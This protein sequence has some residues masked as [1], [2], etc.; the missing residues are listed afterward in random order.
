[1]LIAA[2]H[3]KKNHPEIAVLYSGEVADELLRGYL[4]NRVKAT[5]AEICADMKKRLFDISMFDGLRA[6]RTVA[7]VGME[8]RLPFFSKALLNFALTAPWQYLDPNENGGI[9]KALLRAAFRGKGIIPDTIINRT[10]NAFSDATSNLISSGSEWKE[11]LKQEAQNMV[12]LDRYT[13][14]AEIY[15]DNTPDTIEDMWYREIYEECGYNSKAIPY[16]WL[17][18]WVGAVSDSSATVLTGVNSDLFQSK[19]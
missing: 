10:K 16:K 2:M 11:I 5:P 14:R 18:S 1:M 13:H 4:Y 12:T 15:S 3:I 8:L 9:E 19:K 6:D 7:S 17:P